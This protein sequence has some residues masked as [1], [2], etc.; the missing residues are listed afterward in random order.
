MGAL[1]GSA[2]ER[3]QSAGGLN[4]R[5]E[6]APGREEIKNRNS[7]EY[8]ILKIQLEGIIEELEGHFEAVGGRAGGP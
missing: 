3:A 7:E 4:L 1:Q 8:N 2:R 6:N 5:P